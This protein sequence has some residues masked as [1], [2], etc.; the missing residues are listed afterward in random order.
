MLDYY[1]T[2]VRNHAQI[3]AKKVKKSKSKMK[4][5]KHNTVAGKMENRC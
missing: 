3:C 1:E 4:S 5:H 2:D